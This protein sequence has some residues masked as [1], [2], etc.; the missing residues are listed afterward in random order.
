MAAPLVT[1]QART[2]INKLAQLGVNCELA[3]ITE[4]PTVVRV[5][6]RPTDGAKMHEF[7]RL[8]RADDLAFAL[9]TGP[10][11]I[12]APG[13]GRQTVTVEFPRA[14]RQTVA[15]DELP[16][17][18]RPLAVP[19]GVSVG[20][21]PVMLDI[22]SAPHV[23]IA[24]TTGSGKTT[25][26]HS[27]ICALV[28]A[29]GPDEL[30]L[31]LIDLKRVEMP[32]YEG[33]PH[34]A[35]PVADDVEN[36]VAQLR[37]MV[38]IMERRYALLQT[39]GARNLAHA[40]EI[41]VDHELDPISCVIGVCDELAELMM[42]SRKVVEPLLVRIAQKG[43]AAGVHLILATQTPRSDVFTGLLSANIPTRIGFSVAKQVDSRVIM[44]ANGCET[45]LGKGDGLFSFSGLPPVRFQAPWVSPDEVSKIVT[46]ASGA[47]M[48]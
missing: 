18:T 33:I 11:T 7:R 40:N 4:G 30:H 36:A 27:M 10:V 16:G 43:R 23:L 3:G 47:V 25:C 6:V 42:A 20:G 39:L 34:L 1:D 31:L 37:G 24:G 29:M 15:L 9:G 44:D 35:A 12:T 22:A 21:D 5:D 2:V 17:A 8:S 38:E 41:L 45:L 26:L 48:S 32:A 46:R 14:D 13:H 28:S 19:I